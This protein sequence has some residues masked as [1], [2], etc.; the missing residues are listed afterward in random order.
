[1]MPLAI[2]EATVLSDGSLFYLPFGSP[3]GPLT[4]YVWTPG[5]STWQRLPQLPSE[6]KAPGSLVVTRGANGHDTITMALGSSGDVSNPI[7]YYVIRFQ[8]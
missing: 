3:D 8:M 7:A 1:M 4:P 2:G 6:V 5:A